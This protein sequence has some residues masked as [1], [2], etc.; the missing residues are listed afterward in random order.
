MKEAM[1][2]QTVIR[3]TKWKIFRESQNWKNS[4]YYFCNLTLDGVLSFDG[5]V[6]KELFTVLLPAGLMAG[7]CED[8]LGLTSF[9]GRC[10]GNGLAT[11]GNGTFSLLSLLGFK[12]CCN[13]IFEA[14]CSARS[15]DNSRNFS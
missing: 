3:S 9:D 5:V 11:L 10:A 6:G 15:L 1:N 4:I 8:K 12:I 13:L 7:P 2:I 14:S